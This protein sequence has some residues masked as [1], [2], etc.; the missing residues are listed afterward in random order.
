MLAALILQA[1]IILERAV[2]EVRGN[3]RRIGRGELL[4]L[5]ALKRYE[6]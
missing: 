1:H 4:L 3:H 6:S 2:E 5:I